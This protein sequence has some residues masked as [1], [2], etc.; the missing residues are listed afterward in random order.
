M[1]DVE[2]PEPHERHAVVGMTG[3]GKSFRVKNRVKHWSSRGGSV[4]WF[5]VK[6]EASKLGRVTAET[7]LGPLKQRVEAR[8]L[9]LKPELLLRPRL[10]LAVVPPPSA[11]GRA[12]AFSMVV[13]MLIAAH[14]RVVLVLD[15]LHL[16][17]DSALHPAC[18]R[19]AAELKTLATSGRHEGI[20]L[21]LIAQRAALIPLTVR[22]QCNLWTSFQQVE[23]EDLELLVPRIGEER[24]ARVPFLKRG[25]FEECRGK[26]Q[27]QA[28]SNPNTKP[29][30]RVVGGNTK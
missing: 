11:A 8:E 13:K 1:S 7:T 14:R 19:A 30:L 25:E 6:D 10:S 9:A 22:A 16:Y 27:L 20:A 12:R 21:V 3:S 24:V 28:Q 23:Q 26:P 15:E 5:D 17:T 18:H 29:A 2:L 4:V